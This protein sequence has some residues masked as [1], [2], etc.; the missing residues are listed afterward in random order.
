ML[1]RKCLS[2]KELEA[3]I[4][5]W[6]DDEDEIQTVNVLPPDKVDGASDEEDLNPELNAFNDIMVKNKYF[7]F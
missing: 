4:D 3:I 1:G 7:S 2:M 5:A 6:S